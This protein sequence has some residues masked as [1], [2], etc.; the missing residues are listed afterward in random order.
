MY[1]AGIQVVFKFYL[2]DQLFCVLNDTCGPNEIILL[3]NEKLLNKILF[4]YVDDNIPVVSYSCFIQ[5]FMG[6]EN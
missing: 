6:E 4:V 3:I 2:V 1:V 5:S